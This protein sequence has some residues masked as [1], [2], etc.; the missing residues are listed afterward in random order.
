[1]MNKE[2]LSLRISG[3]FASP[4]CVGFARHAARALRLHAVYTIC[5]KKEEDKK[6]GEGGGAVDRVA[7]RRAA[8]NHQRCGH[9]RGQHSQRRARRATERGGS[10][11]REKRAGRGKRDRHRRACRRAKHWASKPTEGKGHA[12]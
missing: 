7:P 6:R 9:H 10:K 2:R 4:G 12:E 3:T 1:M 5:T 8:A 11:A